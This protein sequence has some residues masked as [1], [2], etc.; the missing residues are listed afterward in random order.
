LTTPEE[1]YAE[2]AWL[3]DRNRTVYAE[4]GHLSTIDQS[5]KVRQ[6]KTAVLT[7]DPRRRR[8]CAF[9]LPTV[10]AERNKRRSP[11]VTQPDPLL[12]VFADDRKDIAVVAPRA[13]CRVH[14]SRAPLLKCSST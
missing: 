9:S 11:F 8:T 7:N 14:V 5:G 1:W 6:P 2:L 4:S 13:Y 12:P 10:R 3:A